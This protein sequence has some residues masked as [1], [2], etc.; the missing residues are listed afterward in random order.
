MTIEQVALP[1]A[2]GVADQD[3][4]TMQA[5]DVIAQTTRVVMRE[6]AARRS[7]EQARERRRTKHG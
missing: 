2:G 1:H 7:R 6:Q 3:A 5:L 4:R